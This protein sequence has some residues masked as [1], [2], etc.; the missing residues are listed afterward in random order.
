MILASA[1]TLERL[2]KLISEYYYGSSIELII[3]GQN[4][5][6]V[7]NRKG[8]IQG[9]RVKENISKSKRFQFE[10]F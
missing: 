7:K 1:P 5:W 4:T 8:Q 10:E 9:V 3:T 6:M 2:K